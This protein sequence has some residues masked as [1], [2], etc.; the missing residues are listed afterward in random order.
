M[1]LY[2][3]KQRFKGEKLTNI[4][5]TVRREMEKN[6][7]LAAM[8]EKSRIAVTAGSRG[9]ADIAAI[10]REVVSY[11]KDRGFDPFLVAAMGSHGG[12]TAEGQR[13]VLQ[14]LGVTEQTVG[15]PIL[16]SMETIQLGTTPDQLPVYM[17]RHAYEADG[18][19]VVNRVKAH[20]AFHGKVESGLSKMITI[21]LGKQ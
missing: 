8:P 21:G 7:R 19:I 5:E 11:L 16:S 18:I 20:T 12:A 17:D 2:E 4:R 13:E 14:Q 15:A 1:I 10:L 3:I 9:I 6:K